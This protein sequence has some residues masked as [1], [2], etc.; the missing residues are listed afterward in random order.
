MFGTPP[1]E[2]CQNAV[3]GDGRCTWGA[4]RKS[5]HSGRAAGP[6]GG[7]FWKPG[8]PAWIS[9]PEAARVRGGINLPS[10]VVEVGS[11]FASPICCVILQR[12]RGPE[13]RVSC[14]C[15]KRATSRDQLGS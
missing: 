1:R 8:D 3:P 10:E 15:T 12:V 14:L 7:S 13:Y 4:V 11:D 5:R 2:L 6:R 9:A